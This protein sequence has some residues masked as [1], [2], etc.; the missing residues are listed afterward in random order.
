[1]RPRER[2]PHDDPREWLNRA[3]SNLARARQRIPGTYLEDAC[4]DAQQAAEK[5]VK[6]LLLARPGGTF[7]LRS[8]AE[9]PEGPV[10]RPFNRIRARDHPRDLVWLFKAPSRTRPALAA[11]GVAGPTSRIAMGYVARSGTPVPTGP[12]EGGGPCS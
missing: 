10:P 6:G 1:M 3:R 8:N 11:P 7:L 4:F 9:E 5:A 2:F 12:T